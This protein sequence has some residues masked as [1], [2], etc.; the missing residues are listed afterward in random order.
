ME[1]EEKI[2]Q[3][4]ERVAPDKRLDCAVAHDLA[5]ELGVPLIEIGRL[6]DAMG[7]KIRACQL[8]CF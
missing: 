6:A 5:K 1:N 2:R 3:A 7:I 8:G 4:L